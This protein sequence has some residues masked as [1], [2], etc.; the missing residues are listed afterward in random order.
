MG[1]SR[2]RQTLA[3]ML[4]PGIIVLACDI[5]LA[6]M[7]P[8]LQVTWPVLGHSQRNCVDYLRLQTNDNTNLIEKLE[9]TF[10]FYK[11]GQVSDS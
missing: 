2:G 4:T 11:V 6:D 1:F 9:G 10:L 7:I 3:L 5:F 8:F